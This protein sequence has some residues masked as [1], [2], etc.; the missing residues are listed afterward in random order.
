MF[1]FNSMGLT[2][3]QRTLADLVNSGFTLE[4][5]LNN[6]TALVH[7]FTKLTDDSF[8]L[9]ENSYA[10]MFQGQ[11][12]ALLQRNEIQVYIIYY[13]YYGYYLFLFIS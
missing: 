7:L 3:A 4:S 6:R 5:L 11:M 9:V 10:S 8:S 12:T 2:T 1:V 13:Y